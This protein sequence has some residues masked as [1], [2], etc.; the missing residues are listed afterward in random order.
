MPTVVIDVFSPPGSIN[1]DPIPLVP[2]VGSPI[3]FARET[4]ANIIALVSE[5]YDVF[6]STKT[7]SFPLY[8]EGFVCPHNW[9]FVSS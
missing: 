8:G 4:V 9:A 3:I 5:R 7:T 6:K 2:A 1:I